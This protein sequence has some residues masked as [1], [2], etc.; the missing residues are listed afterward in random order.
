MCTIAHRIGV[1]TDN[2]GTGAGTGNDPD[3]FVV[4]ESD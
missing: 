4:A 1:T 3:G 2:A